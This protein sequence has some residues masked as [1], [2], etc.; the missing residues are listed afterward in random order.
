MLLASCALPHSSASGSI[1]RLLGTSSHN[2]PHP[3]IPSST[4][5]QGTQKS[6]NAKA[7][8]QVSM[9]ALASIG[10]A[11]MLGSLPCSPHG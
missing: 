4:H 6:I 2:P 1:V 8:Q 7:D 11:T 3:T 9:H 5:L 10:P